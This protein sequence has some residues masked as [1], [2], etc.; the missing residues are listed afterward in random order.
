MSKVP[1][2]PAPDA[3]QA[4]PER[5]ASD[6]LLRTLAD[7]VPVAIAY[8]EKASLRCTFANRQYAESNG[9]TP[10]TIVGKTVREAIG[11]AAY[12]LIEPHVEKAI[13]GERVVYERPAVLPSG[14]TRHIEVHLEPHFAHDHT[15]LGAFVLITDIT[16]HRVAEQAIRES[17]ERMRKFAAVTSEGIFFHKGGIVSDV[18]DAISTISG[19]SREEL[20]GRH[21]LDFVPEDQ[22]QKVAEYIRT[23]SESGIESELLHRQG[24]RVPVEVIGKTIYRGGESFRLAVMRD[25]SERKRAEAHIQ[26]LARHDTL[27]GLPNRAFLGERLEALLALARRHDVTAA[28]L[29][30]DL[31]N[32][33]KVNDSLGH[34]AGDELLKEVATRIRSNL[35]DADIV[36]R[37]GGDEFLVA[38]ADLGAPGDAARVAG[39]LLS[40]ISAPVVLEG[41]AVY[42][43]PSIGIS[44]FPRDGSSA[45]D[46]IRHADAA[47]YRAKASGRSNFQ[48]YAPSLSAETTGALGKEATLREAIERGEFEMHYQPQVAISDGRLTGIE[49]LVRWRHPQ[50]GVLAPAE[51]VPFAEA[52]GLIIP[53]G[54]WVLRQACL[55]MRAW[56]DAGYA[57]AP[58]GV[59]VAA[60]QFQRDGLVGE[61]AQVLNESGLAPADLEIELTESCLMED[62]AVADKLDALK[63]LGVRI[64]V[65]DFGTGYSSPA[66]LKR[67]PIGKLKIDRS[68]IGDLASDSTDAA[69]TTA[70]IR[71]GKALNLAVLAEGV[72]TE[73]QLT[74]LKSQGCDEMQGY[75]AGRPQPAEEFAARYLEVSK[76]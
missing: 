76:A 29:F 17:E 13:A 7:N 47:M 52:R 33:K 6:S 44:L 63:A 35:R 59:N 50:H 15:Q 55:Q 24:H 26:Y 73:S 34:H 54:R 72:E 5:R 10:D 25:I 70:I 58:V 3:G 14:E 42:V 75:L 40:A 31:D 4:Y 64:A 2:D 11:D 56:R 43:T 39:K 38:L 21:T 8:Y 61:I 67:Y 65:D 20:I 16:R 49:A 51:F 74:F 68:F 22:R 32:F 23:G 37:L 9:W 46:L 69:I 36:A 12:R 1:T 48:F 30:I 62:A 41:Q 45:D 71:L 66:Y 28:I 60:V 18:N 19:Y 57:I 53:I 27:T